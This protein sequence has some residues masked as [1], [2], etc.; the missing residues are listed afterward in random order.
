MKQWWM[1]PRPGF[2]RKESRSYPYPPHLQ[3]SLCCSPTCNSTFS[4]LL[5]ISFFPLAFNS[6]I[7]FPFLS[8][9][10]FQIVRFFFYLSRRVGDVGDK[11][12]NETPS[13]EIQVSGTSTIASFSA[14]AV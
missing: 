8:S 13:D 14:R 3:P 7:Q 1:F 2:H 11:G 9:L 12:R 6:T 5:F 4:R 10:L